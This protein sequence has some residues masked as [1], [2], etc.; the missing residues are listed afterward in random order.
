MRIT[1]E[2]LIKRVDDLEKENAMLKREKKVANAV[3]TANT[4]GTHPTVESTVA[5]QVDDTRSPPLKRKPGANA[6]QEPTMA[7]LCKKMDD[8]QASWEAKFASV[9]QAI[10]ALSE[11]SQKHR[12]ALV[13]INNWQRETEQKVHG[14]SHTAAT[15]IPLGDNP[16][17]NHGQSQ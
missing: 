3:K 1:V 7:D 12:A 15:L 8:F 16:Q 2:K 10:Q 9:I 13:S 5:M 4:I 17:F 14:G 6:P 11:E